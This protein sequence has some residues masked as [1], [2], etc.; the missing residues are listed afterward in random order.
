MEKGTKEEKETLLL[1]PNT[2]PIPVKSKTKR[3]RKKKAAP[4]FKILTDIGGN[5]IVVRFD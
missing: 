3:G 5:E 2:T 1:E 4:E